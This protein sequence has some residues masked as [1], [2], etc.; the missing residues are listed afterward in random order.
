MAFGQF[1]PT[2]SS[3]NHISHEHTK[4]ITPSVAELIDLF[5]AEG[6]FI[7]VERC[8]SEKPRFH[9][10]NASTIRE[11]GGHFPTRADAGA[12]IAPDLLFD[13]PAMLADMARSLANDISV[14]I[15][16]AYTEDLAT[17][18]VTEAMK[19]E[20]APFVSGRGRVMDLIMRNGTSTAGGGSGA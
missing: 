5:D 19:L 6:A 14:A 16:F 15:V 10:E 1:I 13:M 8:D 18:L 4:M 11:A 12:L 9:V 17:R 7:F 3:A 20:N 2:H